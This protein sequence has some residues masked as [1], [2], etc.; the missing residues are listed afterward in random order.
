MSTVAIG[1]DRHAFWDES[2]PNMWIGAPFRFNHIMASSRFEAII[3][4]LTFIK[5][6]PPS[7]KGKFF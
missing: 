3:S 2:E 4:A 6:A 5:S 7:F 1:C